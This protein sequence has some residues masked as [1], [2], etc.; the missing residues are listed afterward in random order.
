MT[1]KE[2]TANLTKDQ[3]KDFYYLRRVTKDPESINSKIDLW[4]EKTRRFGTALC[5]LAEL[6]TSGDNGPL[7][8]EL[9]SIVCAWDD[10]YPNAQIDMYETDDGFGI[11]DDQFY[12]KS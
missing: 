3:K 8:R 11:N 7:Y 1:D 2:L 9:F 12:W 5:N 4:S 6:V 10:K